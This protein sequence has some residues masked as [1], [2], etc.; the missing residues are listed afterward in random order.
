MVI[1]LIKEFT[2]PVLDK[3]L[4][5]FTI[6]CSL[7]FFAFEKFKEILVKTGYEIAY[8]EGIFFHRLGRELIYA[9]IDPRN[10]PYTLNFFTTLDLKQLENLFFHALSEKYKNRYVLIEGI[11]SCRIKDCFSGQ[12]FDEIKHTLPQSVVKILE[13]SLWSFED[14]CN[15]FSRYNMS[16]TLGMLFY[17]PP[18]VGKTYILRSFF[19]KLLLERNFTIVQIYQGCLD[20]LNMSVLLSSC[21]SLFPC[22]LFLEDIDVKFKDRRDQVYSL[23]GFLLETFEGLLQVEKVV[24]IATSNNVD[25]IEKALLRPGRI[26]YLIELEKPSKTAKELV[27]SKYLNGSDL[28]LPVRLKELLINIVDTFAEL[29][30]ALQHLLRSY[31]STGDFPSEEEVVRMIKTWKEVKVVGALEKGERRMGLL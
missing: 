11:E 24:L 10:N 29:K 23:V 6:C 7:H 13:N 1:N 30:G 12:H 26:D 31:V 19:N 17:G 25:M 9:E 5:N 18:G 2:S 4:N 14:F 27:L 22:I 8:P 20:Y 21:Q 16:S 28:N 15:R 3:P